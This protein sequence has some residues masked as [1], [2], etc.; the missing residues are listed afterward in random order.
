[1]QLL[2]F[3]SR[4]LLAGEIHELVLTDEVDAGAG[5]SVDRVAF[6]GFAE[7][8]IGGVAERGDAVRL[9]GRRFGRL[10]GFDASHAPN[11]LNVLIAV[12][13]LVPPDDAEVGQQVALEEAS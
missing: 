5:D 9:E 10:L 13:V 4:C 12:P 1:M 6:L 8:R 11:H 3:E 7:I 2:P